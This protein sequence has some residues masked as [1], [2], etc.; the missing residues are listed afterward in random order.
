LGERPHHGLVARVA[1][2]QTQGQQHGTAE[3]SRQQERA[4]W[5]ARRAPEEAR[6]GDASVLARCDAIAEDPHELA[7]VD[8][9]LD[10]EGRTDRARVQLDHAQRC[11]RVQALEERCDPRHVSR[12]HHHVHLEVLPLRQGPQHVEAPEVRP[13]QNRS[14][15]LPRELEQMLAADVPDLD[16]LRPASPDAES[17]EDVDREL[18]EVE[19]ALQKP[20]L[21]F[22]RQAPLG[23]G[24]QSAQVLE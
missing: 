1:R 9:G 8:A 16:L 4:E 10:L 18:A 6:R 20:R 3:Q 12:E 21:A 7:A 14:A 2:A 23:P 15:P 17:V 11:S 22:E 13:E 24:V 5:E 19:Q